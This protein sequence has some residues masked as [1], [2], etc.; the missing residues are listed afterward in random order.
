MAVTE[1]ERIKKVLLVEPK[2]K[3]YTGFQ[4]LVQAEPLGLEYVAGSLGKAGID[5]AIHDDRVDER[6][7]VDRVRTEKPDL[8]GIRCNYTA[9]V[10]TVQDYAE[11]IR[12]EVGPDVPIIIGGHHISLRPR[13][14]FTPD[15]TA[16]VVGPGEAPFSQIV[17]S[18]NER[19]NFQA[20][21]NVWR[22]NQDGVF[23]YKPPL[24]IKDPN[25]KL[26][27]SEEMNER[28]KPRRD[29]V[30]QY[31]DG[32]YFL[33]YPDQY[34]VETARGCEYRCSFCSVH[35]FHG[36]A[37]EVEGFE[38]TVDELLALPG[39]A[40]Y[41]NII[42]DLAFQDSKAANE[43]GDA[44][45]SSGR[46]FRFW[47]Q[48]RA[49]NVWPKEHK[50]SK[51]AEHQDMFRKLAK[52]GLDTVLVG[53]ESFDPAELRRVNKGSTVEQNI[54]AIKFL[55]EELGIK[56]WGAQIIFPQWGVEDY[57]KLI[58]INQRLGIEYPQL[59]ILTPLPGTKDYEVAKR[60]G[61]LL[62]EDP[63]KFDFFH[64]V[65]ETKLP[66]EETYRQI[67]RVYRE[68]SSFAKKPDGSF[69]SMRN[70]ARQVRS[71]KADI[72]AGRTTA[73]AIEAFTER[74]KV[75]QDPDIH[76]ANIRKVEALAS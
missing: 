23:E 63:S 56:I 36:G 59:T 35:N 40:R 48:I 13:D 28:P 3:F 66:A 58:E 17:R 46:E 57:D 53:L 5:V 65:V 75:L 20:V 50:G 16:V 29:L 70:A 15:V 44:L 38:R 32:Y 73:A 24:T 61:T 74:F 41:I 52:A 11:R 19:G 1:M 64:W 54:N 26:Y 62:T 39:D 69:V 9:D 31:R 71:M 67:A 10:K 8:V 72:A 37:Y 49:D 27:G 6:D 68:T 2:N 22:R 45:L 7:V 42:D 4:G 34:S 33:C 18:I 12:K 21:P 14:M 30:E 47:A 51:R 25:L 76:I 60:D 55:R 43:M